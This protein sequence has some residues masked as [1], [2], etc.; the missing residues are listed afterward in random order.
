MLNCLLQ[1]GARGGGGLGDK[2]SAGAAYE[3]WGR[4]VKERLVA[5]A[6]ASPR[7]GLTTPLLT[8]RGG[9]SSRSV[10]AL[11][12]LR[13]S[14]SDCAAAALH[15]GGRRGEQRRAPN[16]QHCRLWCLCHRGEG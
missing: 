6:N 14:T 8:N 16:A 12:C 5:S 9:S 10:E 11:C 13:P 1:H 4:Y 3:L 15:C 7:L 2:A